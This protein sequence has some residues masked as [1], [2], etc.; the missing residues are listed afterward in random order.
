MF[1]ASPA[2]LRLQ[3][4]ADWPKLVVLHGCAQPEQAQAV[5]ERSLD[6]GALYAQY[7]PLVMRRVL[8]F[9]PQSE[10]EEV[11]HEVF[12]KVLEHAHTFRAEAAPSTWLYRMTTN[13][14]LNRVRN[15]SRREALWREHGGL[16]DRAGTPDEAETVVFVRQFWRDLPEDLVDVAT[17]YYVDGLTHAE[18]AR[19]LDVSRRTI[20]NRLARLESLAK[21]KALGKE[22]ETRDG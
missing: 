22:S 10:A 7:A 2:Q 20:G 6:V 19:I 17:Y 1:A 3:P 4:F 9:V 13:H 11:V 14:C 21:D 12:V 18:I 15:Q 8:R 16:W 5:S